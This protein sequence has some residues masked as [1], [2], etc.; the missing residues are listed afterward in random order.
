M[1]QSTENRNANYANLSPNYSLGKYILLSILTF[2]I[3][4]I[5]V[6]AKISEQ[7]NTVAGRFDGRHSMNYWLLFLLVGPL[8]CGIGYL[9]WY[10][11]LSNRVG[12]EL[13]RRGKSTNF[14]SGTYWLWSILGSMIFIGP[15]VYCHKLFQSMN[16]LIEDYN[17][18]G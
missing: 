13:R 10:H 7:I 3:Y 9:V 8:T 17:I 2:G 4:P 12:N 15:F 16:T 1:E 5:F 14:G 6:F 11:N 18:N